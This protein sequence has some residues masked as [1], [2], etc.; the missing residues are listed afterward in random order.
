V[1]V[2]PLPFPRRRIE[3]QITLTQRRVGGR[4][5]HRGNSLAREVGSSTANRNRNPSRDII[6]ERTSNLMRHEIKHCNLSGRND[7]RRTE[8]E[9]EQRMSEATEE[10]ERK[11]ERERGLTPA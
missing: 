1:G 9:S 11:S 5:T 10:R 8:R 6:K 2:R 4:S 7:L 3:D